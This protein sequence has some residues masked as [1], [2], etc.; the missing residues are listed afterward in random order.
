MSSIYEF[1]DGEKANYPLVGMFVWAG[2]SS[3]GY[4]EWRGRAASA[5]AERRDQLAGQVREVFAAAKG[6]YGYRRVHAALARRGVVAGPE[7]V[8]D[9]MRAQG[10][11]ACQP[12]P[13]R[14]ATT[15]PD[16]HADLP[17]DLVGRDFTAAAPGAKLVGD[18]T[19]IPT[20]QGWVYLAVVIDCH[21]KAV[22]GWSMATHMR[23]E[24]VSDA[25]AMA[26]GNLGVGPGCVFHSDRGS[27]YTS[28]QYRRTLKRFGALASTGRTGVCWD[29]AMAE[30]FFAAL[31]NEMI[32]RTVY[33]TRRQARRA[34]VE[35]IEVWYNRQRLHSGLGYRTPQEVHD[36]YLNL[37]VAA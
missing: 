7:L 22:A 20:W 30:S 37:Q 23:A 29:N 19:Y 12:R 1:I 25:F 27:Q 6:R 33:A 2:V 9:L 36:E 3:S 5:T 10:L 17:A 28:S 18:I 13:F 11:V 26:A 35:F 32:H 16:A 8:R 31:K 24:L 4:Y 14:P 34:I 15:T 21:T